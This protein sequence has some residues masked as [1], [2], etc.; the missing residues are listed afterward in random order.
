ME[1]R[2]LE[3]KSYCSCSLNGNNEFGLTRSINYSGLESNTII[4][5]RRVRGQSSEQESNQR[6]M[7]GWSV[8][9]STI[10]ESPACGR[11][12]SGL[13]SL[14]TWDYVSTGNAWQCPGFFLSPRCHCTDT[15]MPPPSFT[16]TSE[17][18]DSTRQV[19]NYQ[20]IAGI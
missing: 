3:I 18:S 5:I 16:G 2:C 6:L 20:T 7:K 1:H 8:Q 11:C 13:E 15:S 19:I 17:L 10:C 12:P 14:S 4:H 9:G